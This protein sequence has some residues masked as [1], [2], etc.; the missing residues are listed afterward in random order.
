MH[1]R[2]FI[3]CAA[4]LFLA[5]PF[6]A[7]FAQSVCDDGNGVLNPAKPSGVTPAEIIQRF[8]AKETAFK[9][10]REKYSYTL[11]I[12]IQ[13]LDEEGRIVDG[14]FRQVSEMAFDSHG[15]RIERITLPPQ[16]PLQRIR[17]TKQDFDDIHDRLPNVLTTEVLP[18]FSITYLGKQHVDEIDTYVFDVSP[19]NAKK[20]K[21][22]FKGRVWVDDRDLMIVKTC[23]KTRRDENVGSQRRN[24]PESLVPTFVTYREQIDG[25]YWFPTYC[26][27]DEIL[28][29]GGD[30]VHIREII[31]YTNYKLGPPTSQ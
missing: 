5:T 17:I 12:T 8:A 9:A 7:C 22:I 31:K 1:Y 28:H 20:E 10:A 25:Q 2:R 11:D 16:A 4:F 15:E 21:D 23:G 24:A 6:S 13:T 30:H 19:R 29:F 3:R 14:E 27:A 18:L 26:R